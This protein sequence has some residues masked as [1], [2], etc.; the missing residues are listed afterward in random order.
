MLWV[1]LI[2]SWYMDA[3]ILISGRKMAIG[4]NSKEISVIKINYL[5]GIILWCEW[6]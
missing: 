6:R 1:I 5:K 3:A 2:G 4:T